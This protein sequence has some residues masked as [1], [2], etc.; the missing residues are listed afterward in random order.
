MGLEKDDIRTAV[1]EGYADAARRGSSC[2]EP[3]TSCCGGSVDPLKAKGVLVGYEPEE[4]D[5]LPEGANL[6][7][8]CGNPVALAELREGDV[9]LD[10]GSGAG[11]DCFL[12]AD[13]VGPEGRV[14]GVDMTDEMLELA[15]RNAEQA[16]CD[17]VE[18]RRG[19]I[20]ELPV[21]DDTVDVIVSNCVINLSP[22]KDRV[23]AEA[24]RVL[25][26]G[27]RLMVSDIVL[28]GELPEEVRRS[29]YEYV[30]CV[31]G[32]SQR[33]DYLRLIEEAGFV[34]IE[35]VRESHYHD[36]PMVQSVQV[37]AV[38]PSGHGS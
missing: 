1:R 29:V 9:V 11:I 19:L 12:A 14:I 16:G 5:S 30:R 2:C 17:N 35:V 32:A 8:G 28:V 24:F 3:S 22:E 36:Y 23:F 31:A 7:L 18:F 6:G 27:G 38:K 15:R 34:G 4:L 10:L 13:R 25:S 37:R 33:D 26:P 21:E 20:E